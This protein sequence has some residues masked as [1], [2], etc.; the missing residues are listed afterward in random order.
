MKVWGALYHAVS[1]PIL[2][3]SLHALL[4]GG[5]HALDRELSKTAS[6]HGHSSEL[7]AGACV[8]AV[9]VLTVEPVLRVAA[10]PPTVVRAH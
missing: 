5:R 10:H 6:H 4:A 9:G 8:G 1:L 7:A 2:H 3:A